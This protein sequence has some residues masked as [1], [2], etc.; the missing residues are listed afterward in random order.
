VAHVKLGDWGYDHDS[1]ASWSDADWNEAPQDFLNQ[2][3]TKAVSIN[4]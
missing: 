1:D 2:F 3:E 4:A